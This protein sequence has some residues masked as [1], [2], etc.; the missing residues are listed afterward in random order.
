MNIKIFKLYI[1][2]WIKTWNKNNISIFR[3]RSNYRES[4]FLINIGNNTGEN[5]K[6]D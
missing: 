6:F 5:I 1:N 4:K 3:N 2:I